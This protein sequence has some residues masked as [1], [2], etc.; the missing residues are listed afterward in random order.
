MA[1]TSPLPDCSLCAHLSP[2]LLAMRAPVCQ[3]ARYARTCLPACSLWAHLHSDCS[4][5]THLLHVLYFIVYPENNPFLSSLIMS[6]FPGLHPSLHVRVV[7][8]A[9]AKLTYQCLLCMGLDP[10]AAVSGDGVPS[11]E[12]VSWW[13]QALL[14]AV[15]FTDAV[16]TTC[17]YVYN[18]VTKY[19]N[20]M[21]AGFASLFSRHGSVHPVFWGNGV[22]V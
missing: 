4:C 21:P 8:F 18:S 11:V 16:K 20:H 7:C 5:G 14:K 9:G 2:S 1:H 17:T 13:N 12:I 6:M 15:I 10:H 19:S 3:P 22:T